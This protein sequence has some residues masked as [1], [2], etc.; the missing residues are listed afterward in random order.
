[1]MRTDRLFLDARPLCM[2]FRSVILKDHVREGKITLCPF[3]PFP[4]G[5][6]AKR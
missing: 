5:D 4:A 1:M 6:M 2:I 3:G